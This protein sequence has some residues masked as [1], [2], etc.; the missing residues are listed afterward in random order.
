MHD[1]ETLLN[2]RP[3]G[4]RVSLD[5]LGSST[6]ELSISWDDRDVLL[7]ALGVGAATDQPLK[8]LSYVTE[9]SMGVT[10]QVIPS[11]ITVLAVSQP[12]AMLELDIR[13]F[14]HAGQSF[15]IFQPI[16]AAGQG[17]IE[18]EITEVLDKSSGAIVTYEHRLR[19][20]DSTRALIAQSQ[21]SIF[22][23]G[24]GGFGGPRGVTIIPQQ[25]TRPADKSVTYHTRPEQAL[26]YRLSGDRNPLHSDPTTARKQGFERPILHGLCT[27]GFACRALI[28][29]LAHGDASRLA[30][31][32]A[33]FSKPVYPGDTL[34]TQIWVDDGEQISFRTINC[35]GNVV[36]DAGLSRL[37]AR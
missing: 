37:R 15:E 1:V 24:G 17:T 2:D 20:S 25:P 19:S 13:N 7:Y 3:E 8:E 21:I 32:S 4:A 26:I 23:R 12:P 18:S 36:L 6:G 35:E 34:T 16:P 9:N 14:L 27:F 5:M 29:A 22:V 30:A 11:F 28:E 10:L 33:R 31:M